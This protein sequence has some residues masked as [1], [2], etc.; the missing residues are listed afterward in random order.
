M[1]T[2][3]KYHYKSWIASN[4]RSN[5]N[6]MNKTEWGGQQQPEKTIT[7]NHHNNNNCTLDRVI[8]FK[9][10]LKYF[11]M[12]RKIVYVMVILLKTRCYMKFFRWLQA[13]IK[14]K[15]FVVVVA[16]C[17]AFFQI[18]FHITSN[19][20]FFVSDFSILCALR[21]QRVC[22]CVCSVCSACFP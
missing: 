18:V 3:N 4:Y 22:V 16:L 8:D 2:C 5:K 6:S 17:V 12:R 11:E 19:W 21:C 14:E 9:Y 15:H 13:K 7:Y 20:Q 10:F 1:Q